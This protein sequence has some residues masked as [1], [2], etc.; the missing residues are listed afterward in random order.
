MFHG[1]SFPVDRYAKFIRNLNVPKTLNWSQVTLKGLKCQKKTLT[2]ESIWFFLF[3]ICQLALRIIHSFKMVMALMASEDKGSL[4]LLLSVQ[5]CW[6]IW[7]IQGQ[8]WQIQPWYV[9]GSLW[10]PTDNLEILTS[11]GYSLFTIL[12][13]CVNAR[14]CACADVDRRA[15]TCIPR[16]DEGIQRP[17]SDWV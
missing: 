9:L 11:K 12:Y 5:L 1:S 15:C 10:N 8:G 16:L 2:C 13:V 6:D 14:V 7:E 3:K 17:V 4:S